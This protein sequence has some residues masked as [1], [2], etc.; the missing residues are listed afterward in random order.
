MSFR[1]VRNPQMEKYLLGRVEPFAPRFDVEEVDDLGL[2]LR[3][4]ATGIGAEAARQVIAKAEGE[5]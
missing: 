2:P 4:I 3:V 1:M 5:A